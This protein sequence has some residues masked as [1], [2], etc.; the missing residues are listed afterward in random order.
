MKINVPKSISKPFIYACMGFGSNEPD[1]RSKTLIEE[2]SRLVLDTAEPR[3]IYKEF[4]KSEIEGFLEGEDIKR[5]LEGAD[6][7]VL[8]ALT[9]GAPIDR[10][11]RKSEITDMVKAMAIDACASSLVE[12]LCDQFSGE[13]EE[14]CR[15]EAGIVAERNQIVKYSNSESQ[16]RYTTSRFSPGYGDLPLNTQ[17][18][19]EHLLEMH[20]AIGLSHSKEYLLTPRK[21]VTAVIGVYEAGRTNVES[22]DIYNERETLVD[23]PRDDQSVPPKKGRACEICQNFEKCAFRLS[24]AHCGKG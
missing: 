5:H 4:H 7:C 3:L 6:R 24:G 23:K 8:M 1:E 19:F 21:S 10:L 2:C 15:A 11:I 18:V 13:L 20:K 17:K 16:I 22:A 14:R 9:L 12:D